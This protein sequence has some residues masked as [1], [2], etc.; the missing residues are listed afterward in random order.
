MIE[1]PSYDGPS[2]P[3]IDF[4]YI[5]FFSTHEIMNPEG[6]AA[7]SDLIAPSSF[8]YLQEATFDLLGWGERHFDYLRVMQPSLQKLTLLELWYDCDPYQL[9]PL[10][11]FRDFQQLKTLDL[12]GWNWDGQ[13][14]H[15][16]L[17]H[18]PPRTA[19]WRTLTAS[20]HPFRRRSRGTLAAIHHRL[21]PFTE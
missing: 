3:R 8:E 19:A 13:D 16:F 11:R 6:C 12:T 20:A 4:E 7:F 9:D 10:D 21:E 17:P 15:E 5:R 14:L 1:R 18:I 2:L